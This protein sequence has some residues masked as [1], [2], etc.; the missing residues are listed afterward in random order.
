MK[1]CVVFLR[2]VLLALGVGFVPTHAESPSHGDHKAIVG[3]WKGGMPDQP[4]GSIE[5]TITP[6]GISGRNPRTGESLGEGT[7]EID[8]AKKTID[9]HRV[10]KYGR[11]RNYLGLYSLEGDTLK[12]VSNIHGKNRPADLAHKPMHDQFLMIL[13]RQR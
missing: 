1:T 10:E 6:T 11:G 12:W 9:A 7:Y 4:P 5:L 3:V 2:V 8:P 13:E